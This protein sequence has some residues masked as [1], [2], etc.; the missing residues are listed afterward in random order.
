MI[1]E[2]KKYRH[3]KGGEYKVLAIGEHSETQE[4]LVVYKSITPP[5][6]TWVRP[7]NMFED[8]V[9]RPEIPYTGPRFTKID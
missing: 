6:Q 8:E 2:G 3:F 7:K 1:L 5:Y 4:E 9:D